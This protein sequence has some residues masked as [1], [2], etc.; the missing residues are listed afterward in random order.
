[1]RSL[2]GSKGHD[3]I[4]ARGAARGLL[5]RHGAKLA[6]SGVG[7]GLLGAWA[8]SRVLSGLLFET[9]ATDPPT[10]AATAALLAGV[11]VL[12]SWIPAHR[13]TR[14]DPVVALRAD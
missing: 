5:L 10:F 4:D 2:L 13:A 1:M 8:L 9:T 11:G 7:V 12:A 14:V 6:L 3:R